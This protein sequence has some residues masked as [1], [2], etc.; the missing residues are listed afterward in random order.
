MQNNATSNLFS[1]SKHLGKHNTKLRIM[2]NTCGVELEVCPISKAPNLETILAS[3]PLHVFSG[4]K[5]FS[6][7]PGAAQ[8]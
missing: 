5:H 6:G 8:P 2:S 7:G 4:G 3:Y 1:Q